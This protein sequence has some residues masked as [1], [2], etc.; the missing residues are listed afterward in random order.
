MF[1][2]ND[3][4]Y[5]HRPNAD[6]TFASICMKCFRTVDTQRDEADLAAAE[7]AHVCSRRVQ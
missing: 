4:P 1:D 6:E 3:P 7:E 5:V 2:P